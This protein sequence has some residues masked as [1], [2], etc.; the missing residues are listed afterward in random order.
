[1]NPSRRQLLQAAALGV[2]AAAVSPVL[3]ACGASSSTTDS[4]GRRAVEFQLSW[5]KSVA[6]AGTWLAQ[7]RGYFTDEELKVSV[8]A[9]GPQVSVEPRLATGRCL[10]GMT[11]GVGAANANK[12][13]ASIKIIGNQ[14]QKSPSVFVS[15]AEAPL[16]T[17]QDLVGH[18]L[19]VNT[20]A[21]PAIKQFLASNDISE[22]DVTI[23]PVQ[24]SFDPLVNGQVEAQFG[25]VTATASLDLQGFETA[26]LYFSDFGYGD[27]TNAYGVTQETLDNDR[28]AVIRFM[29]AEIRGWQDFVNDPELGAELT[30]DKYAADAGLEL[31]QQRIEG[32]LTADLAGHGAPHGLMWISDATKDLV[33]A[34]AE[35][36]GAATTAEE[37][38]DDSILEE[39]YAG[40]TSL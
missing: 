38:F 34:A 11:Y 33:L 40:K 16:T 6:W 19:G 5:L 25:Y 10:V 28:D 24:G 39:V 8:S 13:G 7:E 37:L 35:G 18:K 3:T 20:V 36:A 12:N 23:V 21:L 4:S 26:K 1:M 9:G 2:T 29:T 31:E 27:V 17:P 15:P 22:D 32:R 30:V 14:Y